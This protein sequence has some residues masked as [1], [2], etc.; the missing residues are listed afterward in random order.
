MVITRST[1][2]VLLTSIAGAFSTVFANAQQPSNLPVKQITLFS[3]GVSYTERG[4][5]IEGDA[6]VPLTF[7]TPQINDILKSLVLIDQG[8]KVLPATYGSRDPVG[9]ALQSFAVDVTQNSD[10]NS[11]LG[12]LRGARVS[13]SQTGKPTIEGEILGME[14]HEVTSANAHVEQVPYLNLLT[15]Q[16]LVTVLLDTSNTVKLLNERLNKEFHEALQL[17]AS[18]TDDQRR[19]VTLHFAGAGKRDVRVGY[20]TEAPIWKMSYRLLVDG[21]G[22]TKG[23]SYLQGWALVENTTEEDW[24]GVNLSLVSGRPISFIQDLYQ[25]LYIPRPVVPPD[26]AASPYPQTHGSDIA[27]KGVPQIDK[28]KDAEAVAGFIGPGGA[29]GPSGFKAA[30]GV[31][32]A[33]DQRFRDLAGI[34]GRIAGVPG[35][36]PANATKS[37]RESFDALS[38]GEKAGELFQYNVTTPVNLPRQQAAMIPVTAQDV[39][40]EKVSLFNSSDRS[41]YPLNA[42]RLHNTTSLHLK[43]GPVTLF[44]GGVYAGDA[45]MEDVLPGDTRLITYAVDLSLQCDTTSPGNNVQE[46]SVSIKRGVLT[47]NRREI[48]ETTYTVHSSGSAQK[49]LLIEH[50]IVPNSVLMEPAQPGEK[51]DKLYRFS[52]KMAPGK[53]ETLKVVTQRPIASEFAVLTGDID[54]LVFTTNRKDIPAGLKSGLEQVIARRRH[55]DELKAA[56]DTRSAEITA[57]SSDQ[58]R[59][60]KNMEALDHN[61]ALYKRYVDELDKQET[62]IQTLRSEAA[63]LTSDAATAGQDLKEYIDKL[64][65]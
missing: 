55:I 19:T 33:V 53:T 44:D 8:G 39:Q 40:T 30:N 49:E 37:L 10:R 38:S 51:T 18:G 52:V 36:N 63:K 47:F 50:P 45:R 27:A 54:T 34:D 57:M 32:G 4:G 42:V 46:A 58:E 9:R 15:D 26:V 3:S 5:A 41:R 6:A 59:I 22:K 48:S 17:L 65:D 20:V 62:K 11:I 23:T 43:G 1:R 28:A 13:V 7:R 35:Y 16:G 12:S 31:N 2:L 14:L 21:E 60:R 64:S 24:N 25:P 29:A 56:A 61:S